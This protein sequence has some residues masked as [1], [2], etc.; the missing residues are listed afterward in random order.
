MDLKISIGYQQFLEL[1]AQLPA[2][3]LEKLAVVIQQQLKANQPKKQKTPLQKLLLQAP[4]WKDQEY[5]NY[6]QAKAH[7][8]QFR[9]A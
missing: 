7:L 3:E 4:T 6:L 8:N 5:Q 2:N 9:Q 1:I